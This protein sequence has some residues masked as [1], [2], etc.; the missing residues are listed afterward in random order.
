MAGAIAWCS[1][2]PGYLLRYC[3]VMAAVINTPMTAPLHTAK[4]RRRTTPAQKHGHKQGRRRKVCN[5][6]DSS[7]L[8]VPPAHQASSVTLKEGAVHPTPKSYA[9]GPG[10]AV[11]AGAKRRD[12]LSKAARLRPGMETGRTAAAE[13][14]PL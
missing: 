2:G 10:T 11:P 13:G 4:P 1:L 3:A 5:P 7:S 9:P 6:R 8:A 14:G 12:W